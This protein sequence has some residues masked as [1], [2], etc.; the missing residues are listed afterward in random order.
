MMFFCDRAPDSG[1]IFALGIVNTDR[2][3]PRL[4]VAR[5]VDRKIVGS[6][7]IVSD[8]QKLTDLASWYREFA[9]KAAEPRIWHARIRMAEVLEAEAQERRG[10]EEA[11]VSQ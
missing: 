11:I 5:R 10:S 3:D 8:V 4:G 1:A 9:E 2:G 6:E 7:G